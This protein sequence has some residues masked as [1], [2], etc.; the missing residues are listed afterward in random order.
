MHVVL[1]GTVAVE[2]EKSDMGGL[3]VIIKVLYDGQDFGEDVNLKESADLSQAVIDSLNEQTCTTI[4]AEKDT[5]VISFPKDR[6][7]DVLSSGLQADFEAVLA[8]LGGIPL[9]SDWDT[10][11][12]LPLANRIEKR[13]YKF[14]EFILREGDVPEGLYIVVTG[15]CR[16]GSE[17][18][19]LRSKKRFPWERYAEQP[20]P[21]SFKGNFADAIPEALRNRKRIPLV[22]NGES[23]RE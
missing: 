18:T 20:K 13:R 15:Q 3:P 5:Y 11:S 6:C 19:C 10:P 21:L 22:T 16:V 1:R 7:A 14:G 12:L 23:L 2:V 9:F 17:R 8:F 4:A